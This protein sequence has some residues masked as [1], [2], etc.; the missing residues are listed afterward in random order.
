MFKIKE[1]PLKTFDE[2][3]APLNR[4]DLVDI[5]NTSHKEALDRLCDELM[6]HTWTIKF[7]IEAHYNLRN[8]NW[9]FKINNTKKA[10]GRCVTRT[11][12]GSYILKEIQL[13][14]HFLKGIR[15]FSDVRQVILHEFGHAIE[16]EYRGT[17]D[18]GHYWK[19][20]CKDIGY[21]GERTTI[22]DDSKLEFKYSCYCPVCKKTTGGFNRRPKRTY[23]HTSC[24]TNPKGGWDK[25]LEIIQN[26]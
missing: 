25:P 16:I 14:K 9:N 10:L 13:S 15:T 4:E 22:I 2:I 21:E 20:I 1:T 7:R 24:Q 26:Y 17:T 8:L 11:R 23:Y 12:N 18:H 19:Q 6:N 5:R 3:I